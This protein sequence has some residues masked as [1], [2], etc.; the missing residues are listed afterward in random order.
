MFR[1]KVRPYSEAIGIPQLLAPDGTV[2]QDSE[3]VDYL[4]TRFP[5]LP[6]FPDSR[7]REFLCILWNCWGV[8]VWLRLAWMHRWLFE[9]NDSFVK[10]DFGRSFHPQGSDEELRRYGEL[11]ADRMKSY[12]LPEATSEA[13]RALDEQYCKLLRL[14]EAH[15]VEHPTS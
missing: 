4:E 6:A 2:I 14:F 1:N 5:H 12:G 13:R 7:D 3:I 8:R 10:M 9:A 15:L 11:I